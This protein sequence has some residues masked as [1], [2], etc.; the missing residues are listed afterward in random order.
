MQ[1]MGWREHGV[2]KFL[3][4][5]KIDVEERKERCGLRQVYQSCRTWKP[6][7]RIFSFSLGVMWS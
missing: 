1:S 3:K 5:S 7:G 4:N 6:T 2:H